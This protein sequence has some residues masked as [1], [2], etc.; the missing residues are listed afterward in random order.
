MSGESICP[1]CQ[2]RLSDTGGPTHRYIGASPACWD[3]YTRL[4]AGE[5]PMPPSRWSPLLVDAYAAQHPGDDSPQATQSV[6]VHLVVLTAVIAEDQPITDAVEL[7]VAAVEVGRA[8]GGY[9]KLDPVPS[10]WDLV[11]ADLVGAA[12]SGE[13]PPLADYDTGVQ[14]RWAALHGETIQGWYEAARQSQR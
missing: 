10:G 13:L 5:P 2:V 9:P 4:L 6:A 1:G 8:I 14:Q 11:I 7:R 3:L 12:A